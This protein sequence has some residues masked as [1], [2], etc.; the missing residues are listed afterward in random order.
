M[1]RLQVRV[2]TEV[3]QPLPLLLAHVLGVDDVGRADRVEPGATADRVRGHGLHRVAQLVVI[4]DG[5]LGL[6]LDGAVLGVIGAFAQ[7]QQGGIEMPLLGLGVGVQ[8]G[9]QPP[10]DRLQRLD[11]I[12]ADLLDQREQPALF[13]VVV[14]NQLG[15]VHGAG[16]SRQGL[17][18]KK[19]PNSGP[20]P[21]P[22]RRSRMGAASGAGS[23]RAD[24]PAYLAASSSEMF[25][26]E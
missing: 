8:K 15:D 3:G 19:P 21:E 4:R 5:V 25:S 11:I 1:P 16:S 2:Q 22:R 26:F 9:R 12:R 23:S 17:S 20:V 13:G 6:A 7:F 24:Q 18:P 10:P 14:Q